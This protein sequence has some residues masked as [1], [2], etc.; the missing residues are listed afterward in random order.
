M[1]PSSPTSELFDFRAV[2]CED[3]QRIISS[4][5][6][7]KS[8]GVDKLNA[9]IFKDS[10]RVILG[11]LTDTI[12][13][14]LSTCSFPTAWKG[15]EVVPILKKGDHEVASNNRP[16]SLLPVAAKMY[17][18]IVLEQFSKY[19]IIN[20]RLS[21]QQSGNKKSHSTETLKIYITDC[22]L[23][24]VDKKKISALILLDLSK[25]FDSINHD[26]RLHK[27]SSVGASAAVVNWFK[28]YL[29]GRVQRVRIGS[30]LSDPL[31]ITH[32]V[33]QGTI[34]SPLL[35]CIYLNDLPHASK[36]CRLESL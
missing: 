7:N 15:A 20:N 9:R 14:S 11:P 29:T 18:K 27:L 10:L 24:A 16:L 17:E 4:L 32:G 22:M 21:P 30:T 23:D 36:D 12:N 33:P 1:D 8:P 35:F 25:A 2:T 5:P 26:K 28:S 34:L 19:L 6:L 31:L 3:V 13:S